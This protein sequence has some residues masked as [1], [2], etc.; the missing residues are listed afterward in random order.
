MTTVYSNTLAGPEDTLAVVEAY[1]VPVICVGGLIGNTISAIVFL[2]K[3]LR[4][5]SSSLFLAARS[6]SD[7]GFLATLLTIWASSY[8]DLRLGNIPPMCQLLI[9]LTY[10]FGCFSIWLVVFVTAENYIR[11]CR[12]FLVQNMC[13]TRNAKVSMLILLAVILLTYNFPFWTIGGACIPLRK[14]YDFIQILVYIDAVLTLIVPAIIMALLMSAIAATTIASCE[15]RRRRSTS[16]CTNVKSPLMKVT[17]M[18]LAVTFSFFLLNIP[19]HVVRLRLMVLAFVEKNVNTSL[20]IEIVMQ[21]VSQLL[22]YLSVSTNVLIYSVFS[23]KFRK[24]LRDIFKRKS[25]NRTIT[26]NVRDVFYP[27]RRVNISMEEIL[28]KDNNDKYPEEAFP[29]RRFE[30]SIL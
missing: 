24:T 26:H 19:H 11:I 9:F 13:N 10:V 7:N 29:L 8:Y 21:S 16:S 3:S 30:S 6:I 22:Y 4:E 20:S 2:Q 14:Y 28:D 27:T 5:N 23:G 15:R 12:P 1:A 25:T 18:L 17:T